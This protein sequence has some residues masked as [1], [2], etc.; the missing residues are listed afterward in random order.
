MLEAR[1]LATAGSKQPIPSCLLMAHLP[2]VLE[3]VRGFSWTWVPST[4]SICPTR[5]SS[6]D[7]LVGVPCCETNMS[8]FVSYFL[9]AKATFSADKSST[10]NMDVA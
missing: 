8:A 6:N 9:M 4:Q 3:T 7:V 1:S 10:I 5:T 2:Q